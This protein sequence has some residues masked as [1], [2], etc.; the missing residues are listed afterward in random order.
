MNWTSIDQKLLDHWRK[1]G[2]FRARHAALA[3][4]EHQM[5]QENPYTFSRVDDA[6]HDRVVVAMNVTGDVAIPVGNVFAEGATV[7]DAYT[8]RTAAISGGKAHLLAERYVLLEA[9]PET[10]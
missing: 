4:G 6:N 3:R 2:T 10:K 9:A 5:L 8:G 1:L 7:R